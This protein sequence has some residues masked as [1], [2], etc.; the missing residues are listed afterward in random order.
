MAE[1]IMNALVRVDGIRVASRNSAF[2]A[3]HDGGGLKAIADALSVGH[4]L[5]G[6]VRTSGSRLRVTAQLTEVASGYHLWSERFD[7]DAT[8]VF[9]VQDE[10]AA[11]VVEAVK[12]RLGP[13]AKAVQARAQTTNLEAYRWYLK[14][15]HLRHAK[16]DHGGAMRAFEEAVRL[17]PGHAPSWTGLAESTLLAAYSEPDSGARRLRPCEKGAGDGGGAG[18]RVGRQPRRRGVRRPARTAMAGHGSRLAQGDRAA[19]QSRAGSG[20]VRRQPL[21]LRQARRRT[22]APRARP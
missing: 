11:G 18:G 15:R 19:A 22:A 8:D 6:S 4:V 5:E 10:I 3:G 9:A 16:E 20:L 21:L 17:D 2:R 7:R 14:G 12:A 13:G 1:E